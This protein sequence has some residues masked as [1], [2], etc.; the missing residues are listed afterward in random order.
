MDARAKRKMDHF[1]YLIDRQHRL[2]LIGIVLLVVAVVFTL[3]GES[4]G[5][6]QGLVNRAENPKRFWWNVALFFL[7]GIIFI[8][9]YLYH[10]SN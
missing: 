9:L 2:L 8:G 4:I 7:G 3:T 5:R 6:Y 10:I 1:S